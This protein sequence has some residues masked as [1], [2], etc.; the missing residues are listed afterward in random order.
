MLT[1]VRTTIP[2]D[3]GCAHFTAISVAMRYS[4]EHSELVNM[5]Y[6]KSML[7]LQNHILKLSM[8]INDNVFTG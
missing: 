5:N 4:S 7:P 3:R 2:W 6:N 8:V 1:V